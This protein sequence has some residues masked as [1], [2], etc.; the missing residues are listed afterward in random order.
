[1]ENQALSLSLYRDQIPTCFSLQFSMCLLYFK[2]SIRVID[3]SARSIPCSLLR[4][5]NHVSRV[6]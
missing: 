3:I 6:E 4:V 5:G 2:N 1:M